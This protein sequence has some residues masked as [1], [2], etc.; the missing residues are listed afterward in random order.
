MKLCI[1]AEFFDQNAQMPLS[2]SITDQYLVPDQGLAVVVK[3]PNGLD[4]LQVMGDVATLNG[5]PIM[6]CQQD[7][8]K[9]ILLLESM[10]E[11]PAQASKKALLRA[12]WESNLPSPWT[13]IERTR[14]KIILAQVKRQI[15]ENHPLVVQLRSAIPVAQHQ[16]KDQV[17]LAIGEPR[18]DGYA[19]VKMNWHTSTPQPNFSVEQFENWEAWWTQVVT[20]DYQDRFSTDLFPVAPHHTLHTD[21]TA[22]TMNSK[23]HWGYSQEQLDEWKEELTIT[24]EYLASTQVFV[25]EQNGQ[26]IGYGALKYNEGRMEL[27]NLFIWPE[28]MR[29]GFGTKLLTHAETLATALGSFELWLYSV[30]Y[31]ESFYLK[32]GYETVD[33]K[34]SS[35]PGRFLPI[36]RKVLPGLQ[37]WP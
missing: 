18:H 10:D 28:F 34:E 2:L 15:P 3:L 33:Q 35:I 1:I 19:Q 9:W 32:H 24:S 13:A 17:L 25:E 16:N 29:Q 8:E 30:P 27:D 23:A 11:L 7:D 4:E 37:E 26:A 31:A 22:I 5:L 14:R 6:S 20:P 36:M 21:L 12:A